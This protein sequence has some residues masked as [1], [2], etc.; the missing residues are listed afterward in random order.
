MINIR[1]ELTSVRR[2]NNLLLCFFLSK[3]LANIY[4]TNKPVV[5]INQIFK[6]E[7]NNTATISS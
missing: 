3:Q 6:I 5:D 4:M 1:K 2:N 7:L